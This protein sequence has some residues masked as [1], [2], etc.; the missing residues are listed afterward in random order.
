MNLLVSLLM[1]LYSQERKPKSV[2][3]QYVEKVPESSLDLRGKIGHTITRLKLCGFV[4]INGIRYEAMSNSIALEKNVPVRVTGHCFGLLKVE[5]L[6]GE[7]G[8]A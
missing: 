7:A 1:G 3:S 2:K 6:T 5:P 4:E 8:M